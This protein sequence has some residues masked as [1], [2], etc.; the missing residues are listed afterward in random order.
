MADLLGTDREPD[1][2]NDEGVRW[3]LLDVGTAYARNP[4]RAGRTLPE[5]S[6][7]LAEEPDGTRT[8]VLVDGGE[9]IY[10]TQRLEDLGVRIDIMKMAGD[11]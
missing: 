6:A 7:W 5:A 2:T 9:A 8:F 11:L 10:S 3:W 1:F 4:D